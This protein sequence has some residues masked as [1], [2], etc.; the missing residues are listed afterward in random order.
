MESRRSET[1]NSLKNAQQST[2]YGEIMYGKYLILIKVNSYCTLEHQSQS[3]AYVKYNWTE[4]L[5]D[6]AW[7]KLRKSL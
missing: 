7:L 4:L 5:R 3:E 6:F 2:T 1:Y